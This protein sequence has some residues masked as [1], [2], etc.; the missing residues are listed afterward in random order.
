M[1]KLANFLGAEMTRKKPASGRAK[2]AAHLGISR[3]RCNRMATPSKGECDQDD[4]V[5]VTNRLFVDCF[6]LLIRDGDVPIATTL[7]GKVQSAVGWSVTAIRKVGRM[8]GHG[9]TEGRSDGRSPDRPEVGQMS[10]HQRRMKQFSLL[11]T[12]I[13]PPVI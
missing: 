2:Q 3:S 9:H 10:H 12:V 7:A 5:I 4:L 8:V 1:G 13:N 6:C 11:T